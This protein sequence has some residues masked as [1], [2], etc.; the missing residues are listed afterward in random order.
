VQGTVA[1]TTLDA[2]PDL[3]SFFGQGGKMIL[4]HETN[5]WAISYKG[6]GQVFQRRRDRRGRHIHARCFDGIL[7]PARRSTLR[8]GREL[9]LPEFLRGPATWSR[10][11]VISQGLPAHRKTAS[12]PGDFLNSAALK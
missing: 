10:P 7:P 2:T 12:P 8:W 9:Q 11:K 4:A 3:R 5:D 1:A 6:F